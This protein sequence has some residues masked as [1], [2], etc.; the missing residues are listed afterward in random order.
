MK[1]TIV[2]SI[3]AEILKNLCEKE[4]V[5]EVAKMGIGIP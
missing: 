2:N 1:E 5:T 4:G 3:I